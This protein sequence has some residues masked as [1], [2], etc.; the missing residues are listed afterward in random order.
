MSI[1]LPLPKARERLIALEAIEKELE[2]YEKLRVEALHPLANGVN[3]ITPAHPKYEEANKQ[4]QNLLALE[5]ELP[6]DPIKYADLGNDS[7]LS[8]LDLRALRFM[9]AD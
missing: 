7:E 5:V 4:I 8:P 3:Q 9:L 1:R 2:R 6:F